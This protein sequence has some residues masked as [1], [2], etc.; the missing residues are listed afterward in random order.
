[1]ESFLALAEELELKG[2][3]ESSK[4]EPRKEEYAKEYFYN[5]QRRTDIVHTQKG[6]DEVQNLKLEGG[7]EIA[8]M[9]IMKSRPKQKPLIDPLTM[10]RIEPM[11]ERQIDGGFACIKCNFKAKKERSHKRAH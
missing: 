9:P 6:K 2:L 1:M 5:R 4:E 11:I 10:A 8:M 7:S 3:S